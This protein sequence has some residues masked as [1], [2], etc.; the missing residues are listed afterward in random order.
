MVF[1]LY[2]TLCR[3]LSPLWFNK[4]KF[5]HEDHEVFHEVTQRLFSHPQGG[6]VMKY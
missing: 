6:E 1:F 4:L 5:N 3:T 2:V